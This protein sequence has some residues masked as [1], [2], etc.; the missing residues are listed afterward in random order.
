M[1]K[2]RS[3]TK[4]SS[5][6]PVILLGV[7]FATALTGIHHD[8]TNAAS[9]ANFQPGRIM[10]DDVFTASGSMSAFDIQKFLVSK[11]PT[12][13]TNGT[14]SASDF[15][16]P[17]L[18]HAQYAAMKG[19]PAPP[20]TCLKDYNENGVQAAQIIYN[21]AQQYS[22]NPQ[23]LIV[24]LQ[25]EQGLVTDTWPLPSQYRTATGY[26]C[27]D[28][29]ACN[30]TYYGFTNQV[31]WAGKMFHSIITSNP[32][33]YSPYV[34][35]NNYIQW[36][37][38]ASC[39][40]STVNIT[41]LATQ[42]LYDYTPYQPN[43]AALATGYGNGDSCS[44]YGNRNFYLYFT[45]WF[46]STFGS[47]YYACR[48]GSNIAGAATGEQVLPFGVGQLSLIEPNNTSTSCAEAHIWANNGLQYWGAHIGTNSYTF[49]STYS[50]VIAPHAGG[51][52][53]L[54]KVDY[55]NTGSGHLEVHGWDLSMQHWASHVA[56]VSGPVNTIN[57]AIIP[58]DTDGN[59]YSELYLVNYAST[60]S[61]MVEVH[62]MSPT[63]Q[64]WTSHIATSL[65]AIDPTQGKIIAADL[66]GD[67][68]DEFIYI[69]YAG[70]Q[71]GMVEFHIWAPNFQ[72]WI[73]HIASNLPV[74]G[75]DRSI[76]DIIPTTVNGRDQ[77]L[78]VKYSNT[79]S[80]YLEVHGWSSNLQ[81]WASHIATNSGSF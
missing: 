61:G 74:A 66:N 11:V 25:K 81:S 5:I 3:L 15:G 4:V 69:K 75:Y 35:G 24:L 26:G 56:T 7:F 32:N 78:L 65:P 57:S 28:T 36:N 51:T 71:S 8:T 16:R 41:T 64:W 33:W 67:G 60:T 31:T 27:P 19:W 52:R 1:K 9:L 77:I 59:G 2:Q 40:G 23:V 34:Q 68:R 54:F 58:A 12:C 18:T 38:A 17:D 53:Q 39:G 37:P 48:N 43:Q 76:D 22:I 63:L 72:Q 49:D 55:M 13:D 45:D 62:G 42:A 29:A 70:T 21:I 47:N 73:G 10:D 20:Y 44:S 30:S 46:G 80:G 14:Q 6:I 50:R 79:G